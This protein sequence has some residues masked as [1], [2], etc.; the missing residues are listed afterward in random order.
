MIN[1]AKKLCLD[2]TPIPS[3]SL[4]RLQ[5]TPRN[6]HLHSAI[7]F[8]SRIPVQYKVQR[9]QLRAQHEDDHYCAAQFLYL[10]HKAIAL[11]NHGSALICSDDKA[12]VPYGSPCVFVSTGVRGKKIIAPVKI[13]L[14]ALDHDTIS[15]PTV[16]LTMTPSVYL[17]YT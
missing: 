15:I 4:V 14:G 8:T 13:T 12:K 1:E 16:Y 10:K 6:P 9:R 11:K 17:R 3:K 2:S 5:F 7:N